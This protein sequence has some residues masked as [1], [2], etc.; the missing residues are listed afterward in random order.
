[1]AAEGSAALEDPEAGGRP[2]A[3]AVL[4]AADSVEA[5]PP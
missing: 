2:L 5:E 3:E 1:M 4:T